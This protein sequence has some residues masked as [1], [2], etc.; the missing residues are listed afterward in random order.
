MKFTATDINVT[1][2]F[3]MRAG[4][5][6]Q[7]FNAGNTEHGEIYRDDDYLYIDSGTGGE[8]QFK[9]GG[10]DYVRFEASEIILQ[11]SGT[12]YLEKDDDTGSLILAGGTHWDTGAYVQVYGGDEAAGN[13][14]DIKLTYGKHTG[15]GMASQLKMIYA[16]DAALVEYI[17]LQNDGDFEHRVGAESNWFN[18]GDTEFGS[19]YRDNDYL[20][21]DSGTGGETKFFIAGVDVG[22]LT[23]SSFRLQ[24]AAASFNQYLDVYSDTDGHSAI[25]NLRKS[26]DD[27]L[28]NLTDTTDGDVLGIIN[29]IGVDNTQAFDLGAQIRAV[30]TGAAGVT[31][32]TDMYFTTY[33]NAAGTDWFIIR[34]DGDI[35]VR[36]G[37]SIEFYNA[38]NTEHGEI[39]RN[40]DYL[41]MDSGT[42]GE[43]K[44]YIAGV[45]VG[46]LSANIFRLQSDSVRLSLYSYSVIGG[47]GSDIQFFKSDNN[48]LGTVTETDDG[49]NLGSIRFNGVTSAP[50]FAPGAVIL[51][52]Q[53]G[54]SGAAT[55]PAK[56]TF[57]TYS[58]AGVNSDQMVL[59]NDGTTRIGTTANYSEFEAD[60]TLEFVGD[61][62]VWDDLRVPISSI[63]R[64]GFTDPAWVQFKDDGAGSTGVYALAFDSGTDEEVFFTAQIPHS[65]DEGTDIYPHV[66]WTPS[67]G[68][69]GNVVWGLEYTWQNINGTFGN[70]T[71]IT[72]TDST[73]AT[74][75]KH[76][77]A[78]FAAIN[79]AGMTISSILVCRLFRD[80][81]NAADTYGS[82][83]FL[84]EVDFHYQID[85]VGSRTET[86]K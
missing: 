20:Y 65:Y 72:V 51:V 85:T 33:T 70:T 49:E 25:L 5:K 43:S 26:H 55:V 12:S 76:L 13:D 4:E 38:G 81:N 77:Y 60:G 58:N 40:N 79:G 84:L 37:T 41:I 61:A 11:T 35:E 9:I 62:T 22:Y 34:T 30:Q 86:T 66:H 47:A 31:L 15:V 73:D 10:T 36:S 59:L 67:D 50:A 75:R 32:P 18:A 46:H 27:T 57:R 42:G 53:V 80:A 78:A 16:S 2:N 63:K 3:R 1:E 71:I 82:D 21:M 52:E 17:I 28:G 7:F 83:A 69:A 8:I 6:I 74:D 56:M 23:A 54:A 29:F 39:Y 14:G 44:F 64:L 45:D 48:T 24:E 68:N 19:I